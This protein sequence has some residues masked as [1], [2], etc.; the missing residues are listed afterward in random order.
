[1][2]DTDDCCAAI[3]VAKLA[4]NRKI[5]KRRKQRVW[6][7]DWLSYRLPELP[8]N[9]RNFVRYASRNGDTP[10]CE[11]QNGDGRR[12]IST[13]EIVGHFEIPCFARINQ[14]GREL[15]NIE[16]LAVLIHASG[17][18]VLGHAC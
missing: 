7:K 9:G 11:K 4:E 6:V 17:P 14:E 15:M 10:E 3:I 16:L 2:S 8:A 13:T 18:L 1:M 12:N 5:K